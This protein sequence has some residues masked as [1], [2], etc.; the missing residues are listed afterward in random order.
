[1]TPVFRWSL[2]TISLAS[3]SYSTP[4]STNSDYG[5]FRQPQPF[6]LAPMVASG[7]AHQTINNSYIIMLKDDVSPLLMQNHFNFLLM[8]DNE[9]SLLGD[10]VTTGL[11]HVY[12][13]YIKGYAGSF[14]ENVI[15]QIRSRPEV[16]YVERDQ[17]VHTT[18]VD[19]QK[20]AP[21]VSW[22]ESHPPCFQELCSLCRS[23]RVLH[24]SAIDLN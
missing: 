5:V 15:G 22:K 11:K 3:Y 16:A 18:E 17:I 6:T 1:M 24:A 23:N 14:S 7:P 2:L 13:S 9:D 21:W 8:A 10:G 4:L 12:N 20:D 19:V